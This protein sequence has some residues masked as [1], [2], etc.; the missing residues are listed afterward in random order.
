[1]TYLKNQSLLLIWNRTNNHPLKF[2]FIREELSAQ[3]FWYFKSIDGMYLSSSILYSFEKMLLEEIKLKI[4]GI[5]NRK[6][7][8]FPE[9]WIEAEM[10]SE[11]PINMIVCCG[12]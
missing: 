2:I 6:E 3:V 9:S 7:G 1:M 12:E 11:N 5:W 10:F 8:Y 4:N